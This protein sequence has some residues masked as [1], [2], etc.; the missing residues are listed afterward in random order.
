[1]PENDTTTENE[2]ETME[3]SEHENDRRVE[4]LPAGTRVTD[5]DEPESKHLR[6]VA[7][8]PHEAR[9]ARIASIGKTVAEVNQDY[10]NTDTVYVCAYESGLDE[11]FGDR[12][13]NWTGAYL[14][15]MAGTYGVETFSFPR[16]RLEEAEERE[17]EKWEQAA[18]EGGE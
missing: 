16:S 5:L 6:V 8:T 10:P 2:S 1:M 18:E 9:A 11:E 3:H 7:E 13:Q 15:L 14:A 4:P 12:W 17:P